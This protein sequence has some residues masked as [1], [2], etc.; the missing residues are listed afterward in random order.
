MSA[1]KP[2]NSAIG[3]T[4]DQA[5]GVAEGITNRWDGKRGLRL[6]EG[7]LEKLIERYGKNATLG[8]VLDDLNNPKNK[9]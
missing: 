9:I 6:D 5:G 7:V 1:E 3:L 8:Q 4:P 2:D